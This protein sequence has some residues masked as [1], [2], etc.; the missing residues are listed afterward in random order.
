MCGIAD[1]IMA[2]ENLRGQFRDSYIAIWPFSKLKN[3]RILYIK[4]RLL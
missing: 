4:I 3:I 2:S 1:Y